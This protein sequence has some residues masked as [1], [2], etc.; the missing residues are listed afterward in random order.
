M[1][2]AGCGEGLERAVDT[3]RDLRRQGS[4]AAEQAEQQARSVEQQ[5]QQPPQQSQGGGG[6]YGY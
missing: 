4:V 5:L 2:A 6:N 1:G 3:A